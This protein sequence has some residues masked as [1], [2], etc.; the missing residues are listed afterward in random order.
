M[1][2][3][4]QAKRDETCSKEQVTIVEEIIQDEE[5]MTILSKR[6]EVLDTM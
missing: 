3:L 6:K 1:Y 5:K 2:D 4:L